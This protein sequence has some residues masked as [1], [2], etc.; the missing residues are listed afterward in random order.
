M[1]VNVKVSS[2]HMS[3]SYVVIICSDHLKND[4]S[5]HWK[6]LQIRSS[7]RRW[8]CLSPVSQ[9]PGLLDKHSPE[10]VA[11]LQTHNGRYL[12]RGRETGGRGERREE[13]GVKRKKRERS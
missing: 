2:D 12:V 8:F 6:Q 3:C 9:C 5:T 10:T 13:K 11:S 1:L 4:H 7:R